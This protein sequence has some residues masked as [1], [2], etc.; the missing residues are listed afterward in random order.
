LT[1]A[2]LEIGRFDSKCGVCRKGADPYEETHATILSYGPRGE[3]CGVR[4]THVMA[5]Y[6]GMDDRVA[7]MRPDLELLP[8][9][10]NAFGGK[11]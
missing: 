6:G 8:Y 2:V 11:P 10:T 3:G 9:P 7:E 1:P 5:V 4:W